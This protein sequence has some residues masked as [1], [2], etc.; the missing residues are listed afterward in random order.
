MQLKRFK[1]CAMM[2]DFVSFHVPMK[3][4]VAQGDDGQG[5]QLGQQLGLESMRCNADTL[6]PK[7]YVAYA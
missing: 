1:G 3:S 7:T 4:T 5:I 2:V 6:P